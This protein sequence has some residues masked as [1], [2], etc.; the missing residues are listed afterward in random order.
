MKPDQAVATDR[1]HDVVKEPKVGGVEMPPR[2]ASAARVRARR[3]AG[4]AAAF[5]AEELR[6]DVCMELVRLA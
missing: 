2:R 5:M 6:R 4:T 1:N 3:Q